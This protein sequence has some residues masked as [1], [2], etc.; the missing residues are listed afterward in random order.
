MKYVPHN[1][2]GLG[3]ALNWLGRTEDAFEAYSKAEEIPEVAL[4]AT[5]NKG[6]LLIRRGDL[7][8]GFRLFERRWDLPILGG[9]KPASD[10]PL[11]L[12]ETS[13]A[14]KVLY[15]HWEQGLGDTIHFCRYVSM[16]ADAGARV[17][18][19]VPHHLYRLMGTLRGVDQLILGGQPIPD[20]DLRCPTVS[21]PLAFNTTI[22][23]IPGDVPY[24]SAD[25]QAAA[26]WKE[27]LRDIKGK[28]IGLIWAG[29]SRIGDIDTV[30][31]D[32]RR[33]TT[34]MKLAPLAD[35]A[36][37]AFFSLQ[38][39]PPAAQAKSPPAGMTLHDYTSELR[40]FADTAALVENLDLVISVDT[41][42]AHLAGAIGKP[43]WLLNRF[44][45]CWRWFMERSDTPWYPTM[46]IFRQP[47]PGDWDSVVTAIAAAL[48]E[49]AATDQPPGQP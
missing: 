5:V 17:I 26:V 7:P 23:T 27:R 45:T 41:S 43:V 6:L 34:L 49:F 16:A 33:S 37:C 39:G 3:N 32:R 35:V 10:R 47:K 38:L 22:D 1:W 48:A 15:I 42:P 19:E 24:L 44:D 2:L 29:E 20:H 46:R 21:L 36:D 8:A 14:G 31:A 28:R 40:D 12:G 25:P 11:W 13:L 30:N 4:S 9:A 18:L